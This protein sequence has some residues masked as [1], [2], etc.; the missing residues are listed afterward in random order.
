MLSFKILKKVLCFKRWKLKFSRAPKWHLESNHRRK[1]SLKRLNYQLSQLEKSSKK[2]QRKLSQFN[3]P[4]LALIVCSQNSK[5]PRPRQ[6][7]RPCKMLQPSAR[8]HQETQRLKRRKKPWPKWKTEN[9]K[10]T[11]SKTNL[12]HPL[13]VRQIESKKNPRQKTLRSNFWNKS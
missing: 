6:S 7:L 3:R 8:G 2:T 13:K 11:L 10:L 5:I 4:K 1:L 12:K 9:A